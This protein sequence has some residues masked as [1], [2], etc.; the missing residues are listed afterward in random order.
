[1]KKMAFLFVVSL[2]FSLYSDIS[3]TATCTQDEDGGQC[4]AYVTDY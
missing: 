4:V 1:M 2:M 3:V